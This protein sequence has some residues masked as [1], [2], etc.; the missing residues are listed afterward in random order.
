MY[1]YALLLFS[2]H[3]YFESRLKQTFSAGPR[4]FVITEFDCTIYSIFKEPPGV[5]GG[6]S[7]FRGIQVEK[8]WCTLLRQ[9]MLLKLENKFQI[10]VRTFH[11]SFS[12]H[13]IRIAK[14]GWIL[15]I[16][17]I[18]NAGSEILT[19]NHAIARPNNWNVR[20]SSYS[21]LKNNHFVDT[22]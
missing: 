4:E 1:Y 16:T 2:L 9:C 19:Q 8:H 22:F 18:M 21:I 20:T 3:G 5:I 14:H 12:K 10:F 7:G 15:D 17:Y 6:T 13:Q 11:K